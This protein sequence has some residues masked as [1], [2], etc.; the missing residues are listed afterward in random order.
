MSFVLTKPIVKQS[1][2]LQSVFGCFFGIDIAR[3]KTYAGRSGIVRDVRV[4][5]RFRSFTQ[6]HSTDDSV[7]SFHLKSR[8]FRKYIMNMR[9]WFDFG[10][11][12]SK[13]R[14]FVGKWIN[15]CLFVYKFVDFFEITFIYCGTPGIRAWTWTLNKSIII[16]KQTKIL[17]QMSARCPLLLSFKVVCSSLAVWFFLCFLVSSCFI[18]STFPILTIALHNF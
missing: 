6:Y 16:R 2:I 11:L 8:N 10:G 1:V 12:Y 9:N 3:K 17:L 7:G 13:T 18:F 15:N 14:S 4:F 5:V